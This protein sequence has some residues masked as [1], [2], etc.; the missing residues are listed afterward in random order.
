MGTRI[1]CEILFQELEQTA[2][3]HPTEQLRGSDHPSLD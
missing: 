3:E 2:R 1:I